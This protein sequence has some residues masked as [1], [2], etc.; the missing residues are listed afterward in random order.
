MKKDHPLLIIDLQNIFLEKVPS[1]FIAK[2]VGFIDQWPKEQ[3]YWLRY[4]NLPD[5]LFAKCID[6]QECMTSPGKDLITPAGHETRRVIDHFGY[7]PPPELIAEFKKV[8]YQKVS[9]CGVD[10]DA[11]VM[12][13]TFSLWDNDIQPIIHANYC[14][15][16][17][18]DE[19]HKA[20]IS[21]M[22]RQFGTACIVYD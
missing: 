4:L 5:S 19:M 1:P 15:S 14:A 11:C 22:Y 7:A 18:G 9:I 16:S 21:M 10:T 17:G 2:L 13:H 8:G 20:A 6:W 3:L 12:A